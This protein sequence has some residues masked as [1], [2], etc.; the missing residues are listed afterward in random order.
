LHIDLENNLKRRLPHMRIVDNN[1]ADVNSNHIIRMG[2][3][4]NDNRILRIR[5]LLIT[6]STSA[7]SPLILSMKLKL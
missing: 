3:F 5:I 2:I 6:A 7:F 4:K 1:G